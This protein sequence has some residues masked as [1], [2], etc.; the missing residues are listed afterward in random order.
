MPAK[1]DE[2][3]Y[4]DFIL[5]RLDEASSS[6]ETSVDRLWP[7][8]NDTT[9]LIPPVEELAADW[10]ET[11]NGWQTLDIELI[12]VT[13][14]M[15]GRSVHEDASEIA[16][17]HVNDDPFAWLARYI[18]VVGECWQQRGGVDTSVLDGLLP[19]QTRA[20]CSARGLRRDLDVPEELK[21]ICDGI[22]MDIRKGLLSI[23]LTESISRLTLEYAEDALTK[24]LPNTADSNDIRTE[25][26]ECLRSALP[27]DADCSEANERFQRGAAQLLSHLWKSG[28][29]EVALVAREVPLIT[30]GKK[31]AHWSSGRV[32]MA[33]VSAWMRRLNHSAMHIHLI[34]FS[35]TCTEPSTRPSS[36]RWRRGRWRIG[37]Q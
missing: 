24:A 2:P 7:I 12:R 20:L 10:S 21:E 18:D 36:Q 15:L 4:A 23:E 27:E 33:P 37:I 34:G 28:G 22:E 1:S 8:V 11:A 25:L 35:R 5:P 17:L 30:K 29:E 14:A 9:T 13:V 19:S 3:P 16:E 26:L 31:I 6:D 32:M